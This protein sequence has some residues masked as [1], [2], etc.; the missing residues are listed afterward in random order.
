MYLHELRENKIEQKPFDGRFDAVYD[1]VVVGLGTAGAIALI[2]AAE[3][4]LRVLGIEQTSAMGGIGTSGGIISYYCGSKGGRYTAIN[5]DAEEMQNFAT[6][7]RA[8]SDNKALA[9]EQ[10]SRRAGADYFYETIVTGVVLDGNKVVGIRTASDAKT[11]V[12]GA[13]VVIDATAEATVCRIAGCKTHL[14]RAFDNQTQ[15]YTGTNICMR[16][17][18]TRYGMN[19][20]AGN[21]CQSD[22]S[23][24]ARG[25]YTANTLKIALRDSYKDANAFLTVAPTLGVREGHVIEGEETVRFQDV[26]L[27]GQNVTD[28]IFY[29]FSNVDSHAKDIVFDDQI[30]ADWYIAAGLWGL[31]FSPAIPMGALIPKGYDGIL[32]AGRSLAVDHNLASCVRMKSDMEKCGE[33]AGIM[34]YL[35]VKNECALTKIPYPLL[36]TLLSETGCLDEKN[37]VNCSIRRHADAPADYQ[38]EDITFYTDLSKIKKELSTN[39][40]GI[41]IWS[42]YRL[43]SGAVDALKDGLSSENELLRKHTAFALAL[44]DYAPAADV[45]R[46][47]VRERDISIPVNGIKFIY[48]HTCSALYLL[49]RLGSMAAKEELLEVVRT[50]GAFDETAYKPDELFQS[51]EDMRTMHVLYALRALC[52]IAVRH[53]DSGIATQLQEIAADGAMTAKI[54]L[55]SNPDGAV[56]LMPKMRTY[57]KTKLQAAG[58]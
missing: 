21:V 8:T 9:L 26:V 50:G 49:G 31:Y 37:H 41:A 30:L 7:G 33:A 23:D 14:G 51:A 35:A 20:D 11:A 38:T 3:K 32:T 27:D 55:K 22:V 39:A 6:R 15:P 10:A 18:G 34:A 42:A 36:Q 2:T 53:R 16:S 13:K 1:V 12:W 58:I 56:D 17:D 46:Q 47:I 5:R 57:I 48:T 25:V 52:E 40:P 4:G 45:L 54:T 28:P 24:Y 44:L 19:K 29:A 43:G